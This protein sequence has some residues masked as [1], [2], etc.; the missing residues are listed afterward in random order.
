MK[1]YRFK[2]LSQDTAG[3]IELVSGEIVRK[4][5]FAT[6]KQMEFIRSLEKKLNIEPKR[7]ENL[8]VWEAAKIITRLKDKL[9]KQ[10]QEKLL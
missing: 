1:V 5:R 6:D 10:N 8:R 4:H 7:Y 3:T 9:D 2:R